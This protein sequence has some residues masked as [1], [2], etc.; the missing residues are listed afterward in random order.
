MLTKFECNKQRL[1]ILVNLFNTHLVSKW[2]ENNFQQ[3]G[4]DFN[5][6][7]RAAYAEKWDENMPH[8]VLKNMRTQFVNETSTLT[9]I[10]QKFIIT[11]NQT[12][13]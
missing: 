11:P 1:R 6:F 10:N 12:N 4:H 13:N 5:T 3:F 2:I 8:A 9:P 7:P